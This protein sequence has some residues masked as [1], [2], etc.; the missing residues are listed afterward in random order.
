MSGPLSPISVHERTKASLLDWMRREGKSYDERAAVLG[1]GHASAFRRVQDG[2]AWTL[3]DL[4]RAICH[5]ERIEHDSTILD[6]LIRD[7]R[8]D[9][10]GQAM[11]A[12]TAAQD[13][14]AA[15]GE[16]IG[17]LMTRVADRRIN[18]TE[19]IETIAEIPRFRAL[20]DRLEKDMVAVREAC[21]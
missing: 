1:I 6:T 15:F 3:S 20:L 10:D 8:G 14:I 4:I 17:R 19:A 16:E 13:A 18:A 7:V 12:I 2:A 11:D 5:A 9:Q 21:K